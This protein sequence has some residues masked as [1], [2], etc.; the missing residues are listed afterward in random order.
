MTANPRR[1]ALMP[2][3]FSLLA[4]ALGA[5]A[6]IRPVQLRCEGEANPIS[7]TDSPRLSWQIASEERN[8]SQSAWQILVA[9]RA[10][11]LEP[12]KADLWDSGK[13]PTTR[14]HTVRYQG[15]T[16]PV[17][18]T[19]HWK[20]RCWDT[21]DKDSE[22]S[23]VATWECA[24]TTPA[25]WRGAQWI[26]DGKANPEKDEDLYQNDPAPLLRR[27]FQLDKPVLRA[28]LHVAGLGLCMPSLNGERIQD[29]IFDPAWTNFDKRILF[30][31][32]DV[33]KQIQKGNNCIGIALGNG[34]FN[35]L[36]L[37]MWGSR[38]IRKDL[39]I[40]RPRAIACLI[41][42][43]PDGSQTT[44]TTGPGW[45]TAEGPTLRNSIYIGE[46]RDARLAIPNWD[47][48]GLDPSAWKLA[49]MVDAPLEP[50]QPLAM[51][52][53]RSHETLTVKAITS[54]AAG[55]HIVDFGTNFT[56][57]PELK[58]KAP[59][60]TRITL[61]YGELRHADGTLNPMTSVCGQ[62]K[63]MITEKDGSQRPKGGPGAP[64]V[65]WQ[66]DVY[67]ASGK[68]IETYRPDF[69]FH[70][71]RFMEIKGLPK[72]PKA[73]DIKAIVFNTELP[74]VG[75]FASSN[76]LFDR[77]QAMCLRTF[78]AN[79][80]TVQS[81]CPHRER[82]GYGGDIVATSETFMMN[83]D[84]AGFYAKTV[85]DWGDAIQPDNLMPDTAP[86]VGVKYCGVG[87]GMAHP[88]LLEQL[89]QHYGNLD[90]IREQLPIALRWIQAEADRRKDGL[91]TVGLG[92][93]EALTQGSR[94]ASRGPEI[95]TPMFIDAARRI[96][97]LARLIGQ[98]EPAKHCEALANESQAAW[99]KAFF[100]PETGMV[101]YD[102]QTQLSFAL[103]FGAVPEAS[104][105]L[106]VEQLIK[107]LTKTEDRPRLTTGIYGTWQLLENLPKY[108]RNDL[109][110][111][112]AIRET[113][114]SW[115]WML[116]NDATT[117]WEHW[118][119]SDN[120]YSNNHPMFG[121]I[122]G[123][124]YRWL[125]GIQIAPDAVAFD[126]ILIQPKPVD[127]LGWVKTSHDTVRGK[128]V[129]NWKTTKSGREYEITIPT[130]ATATLVLP[131]L[132]EQKFTE[133]GKPL[134]SADGVRVL[135]NDPFETRLEV[136]GGSYR[137]VATP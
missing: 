93:H 60:G 87:W 59:A 80:M 128:I 88:L 136:G 62:I 66:E 10:E 98:E 73:A 42:D 124:F 33:S 120:T 47:R 82:F 84:M 11:L 1:S 44:I 6:G 15:K 43:H 53:V 51:K 69:T 125:G 123:W 78:R 46:V 61:R 2:V 127:G 30:R 7:T 35:P 70:A 97:R 67:I 117:L 101:G 68:G 85:R 109:A 135:C 119:G 22:W 13:V 3:A 96:A 104:K 23:E 95:R 102:S 12:Q 63:G 40:G 64:E 112:L 52:P 74:V 86:Y 32:H 41:V 114:P 132:A 38:N 19:Y 99:E 36:P 122:S 107:D 18:K 103:G 5:Q 76:P 75:T 83:F 111:A 110:Y 129:S 58:I 137:F 56:G 81:D 133:S 118:E 77:I 4:L 37:R 31:S 131:R 48:V 91:V 9:S 89:Y 100:N 92:D 116:K 105:P 17:G 50:L 27:E 72:A 115:G 126:R 108:T 54:P 130:G 49:R 34:W 39:P 106:V 113:F 90:L 29:Q 14:A 55:T 16:L 8:Q 21:N 134:E 79:A 25:D 24:P 28:R 65:A 20:V 71:F 121:S 57:L 45:K 26:D 94:E